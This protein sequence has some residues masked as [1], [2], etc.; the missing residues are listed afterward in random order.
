MSYPETTFES[1]PCSLSDAVL[2]EYGPYIFDDLVA[3][4]PINFST[5]LNTPTIS[6]NVN[7]SFPNITLESQPCSLDGLVLHE[8]IN[9]EVLNKLINSDLLKDSFRNPTATFIYSDE[10]AQ[11]NAYKKIIKL[12]N[13]EVKYIRTKGMSFGRCNPVRAL[14]LFSI[15]REIRHTLSKNTFTDIDIVNCHPILL[16]QMCQNNNIECE[17]LKDYVEN[18]DKYL[19]ETMESYEV[20][21]DEAKRLFISLLYFGS[22]EGWVSGIIDKNDNI[23][24]APTAHI[25]NFKT[26]IQTIGKEIME[27]NPHITKEIVKNKEVKAMKD[28]NKIGS[29]VSYF[30]QELEVRI[31][32][33]CFSYCKQKHLIPGDKECVL[34]ADGLMIRTEYY[35]PNLLRELSVHVEK[36]LGFKLRF[37]TKEMDKDFLGILDDH[38]LNEDK[39]IERILKGYN[40]MEKIDKSKPFII[41]TMKRLLTEDI[42]ALGPEKYNAYFQYTNSFRYFD[43][44]HVM[45]TKSNKFHYFADGE[46]HTMEDIKTYS[47]LN[48]KDENNRSVY[49]N[50]LYTDCNNR[51]I[52]DYPVFAPNDYLDGEN[53]HYN[54]FNGFKYDSDDKTYDMEIVKPFIDHIKYVVKEDTTTESP[55]TESM[56]NW[57]AHIIQKPQIKTSVAIILYSLDEGVGK[58]II[59]GVFDRL[60]EGYTTRFRDTDDINTKFNSEMFGK[61]FVVGDEINARI[62]EVANEIKDIIT[63]DKEFIEYKGKDKFKVPDLKNYFFTTNNEKAFSSLVSV[64]DRRLNLIECAEYVKPRSYYEE[65]C[66]KIYTDEFLK[67]M[68]NFLASRNI[69]EYNPRDIIYTEYRTS[70]MID[71]LPA[72]IKFIKDELNRLQQMGD[73]TTDI[74]FKMTIDYAKKHNL[75]QQYTA[76]QMSKKYKAI[77]GEYNKL[78][79]GTRK[80]VYNFENATDDSIDELIKTR[81]LCENAKFIKDE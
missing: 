59:T 75:K 15:R 14:S 46:F 27:K 57:F 23:N 29:V 25:K 43:A 55:I 33:K 30:L 66:S 42:E 2:D 49:F 58:N 81:C 72:Y 11:L 5:L 71:S 73:L 56:L 8:P 37:E 51:Q 18:R 26:E 10:M 39:K 1:K 40:R 48:Y 60:L 78:Q 52:Y 24:Y 64:S 62:T 47:F 76:N 21:K 61:L 74:L 44:Y 69:A 54:L 22:F 68:Y 36:N 6:I 45:F 70:L 65:L 53:S 19:K 9:T 7:K 38:I 31:L 12:G 63:R 32:E 34:C 77:F 16:L 13:A 50:D 80:S 35:Y 3:N 20:S 79:T 41:K 67:N 17:L 4:E 28:Y